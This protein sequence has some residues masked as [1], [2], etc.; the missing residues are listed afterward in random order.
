MKTLDFVLGLSM[1]EA[2]EF[3]LD[4]RSFDPGR[5]VDQRINL[6]RPMAER[7][8][9]DVHVD[10]PSS[11]VEGHLDP[12]CLDR[13]LTTLLTNAIKFTEEGHV[14]VCVRSHASHV[15]VRVSDSSI[16]IADDFIPEL[17]EAFKQEDGGLRREHEG[18]GLGLSITKKMVGLMERE[19][20]VESEKGEGA[21][22]TGRL[23][24]QISDETRSKGKTVIG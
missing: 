7:K 11:D 15:A 6:M 20:E 12:N 19:I 22:F 2:G 16:G 9:L 5:E 13:I 14:H 8:E 3:S 23:P 4:R 17:F 18:T 24:Y 1:I 21:T 10:L